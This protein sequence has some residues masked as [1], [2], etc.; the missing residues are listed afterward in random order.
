MHAMQT[1]GWAARKLTY[2]DYLRFPDDGHRHEL[3]DGAHIVTS[4]PSLR[5]QQIFRNLVFRLAQH[6]ERHGGGEMIPAPFGVVFTLFDV[7]EPDLLYVSDTRKHILSDSHVTGSPDLVVEIL[8]PSTRARD[9][10]AKLRLYDRSDVAEYWVVDP[11]SDAI[12]VYRRSKGRLSIV[13]DLNLGQ[14]D[15]LTSPLLPA[16]SLPL[17]FVFSR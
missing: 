1:T 6:L 3:I 9:E 4:T 10:G 17:E 7:V 8:S 11:A 5:H 16:L 12:R 14:G 15:T 2:Q 13:A